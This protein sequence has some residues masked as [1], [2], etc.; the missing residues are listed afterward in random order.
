MTTKHVDAE[1]PAVYLDGLVV[2]S[3]G[4]QLR[5]GN[6]TPEPDEVAVPLGALVDVTVIDTGAVPSVSASSL[7]VYVNGA[8]AYTGATST[9]LPGFDGP[10]SATSQPTA[11]ARRVVVDHL[12][13]FE[14]LGVVTVRVVAAT[15]D[16]AEALDQSYT[17]TCADVT[18]P[19]VLGAQTTGHRTVRV[20]FDEAMDEAAVRDPASYTLARV[21][22]P[23]VLPRVASV[24]VETGMSVL[25]TLDTD[26]TPRAAYALT[27]A[28]AKDVAGNAA[29][30]PF[31]LARIAGFACPVPAGRAFDLWSWLPLKNRREDDAGTGDL[32][33][34]VACLQ[35]VA[36]LLLCDVDAWSDLLDPDFAPEWTVDR[37]LTDLGNPFSFELSLA[38]K[39]RLVRVLVPLYKQKATALGIQNAVRFFLGFEV[40]IV[41]YAGE[42]LLLGES[43]LGETWVL[44]VEAR[45]AK[46]SFD[47]VVQR[48]LTETERARL[49]AVVTYMKRV[50]THL[51][52]IVEPV[53]PL[54]IDHLELGLSELGDTQWDLH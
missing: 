40:T 2:E 10:L 13:A 7:R 34:F 12:D 20:S 35:E 14:S 25:L 43:L 54:V 52:N 41:A 22:V 51:I 3:G 16:T 11:N 33:K 1:L 39:R 29:V 46:Y 4:T 26:L 18:T 42:G 45:R 27:V 49:R 23:A 6:R 19:K 47:V 9:F 31:N 30:A 53:P 5:L 32:R 8:L 21:T 15:A 38:D 50:G 36:D 44:A 37:M 24:E 28:G 48:I 17:F